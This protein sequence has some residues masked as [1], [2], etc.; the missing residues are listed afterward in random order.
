MR[1]PEKQWP[2]PALITHSPHW[3]GTNHAIHSERYHYIH[4]RD[5][6]EELYDNEADPY[7]WKNLAD[8]PRYAEAKER[9]KKWLPKVNSEHYRPRGIGSERIK[10]QHGLKPVLRA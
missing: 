3:H 2:Y 7:G 5:G 9:L 6:S 10:M 1:N 8:D 4:Y